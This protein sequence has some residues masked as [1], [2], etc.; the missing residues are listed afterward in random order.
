MSRLTADAPAARVPPTRLRRLANAAAG[1][2]AL[3]FATAAAAPGLAQTAPASPAVTVIHAGTLLAVPGEKP[4]ARQSVIVTGDK[5]TAIQDGFVTPPG[6]KV[7]DLSQAFV[8]PGMIDAHVHL[9]Y[10]HGDYTA[11]LVRLE[12]G[13]ELLRGYAEANLALRAGFTTIRDMAGKVTIVFPL[14]DA[15]KQGLVDGPRILAAGPAIEPLGGGVTP[16]VPP[17]GHD[18]LGEDYPL[19]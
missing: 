15:I 1:T 4:K 12:D 9:Q 13:V 19:D 16:G 3:L 17:E 10:G 6:A 7:I 8:M 18:P 11:D 2:L 5:I 14:R